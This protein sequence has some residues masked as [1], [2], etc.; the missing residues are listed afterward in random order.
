M[1]GEFTFTI[2]AD[3]LSR[4]LR[5]SK[6]MP[7]DSKYLVE[8][9]GALGRD[10]VLVAIDELTRL[11]TSV[12][13]ELFPYPQ[14][15][16]FTNFILVC[17]ET[18]IYEYSGGV[19][20]LVFTASAKGSTWTAVD[21]YN[22]LYMSNGKVAVVKDPDTG[23]YSET[24]LLPTAVS[25]LNFNGQVILGS[26]NTSP[27]KVFPSNKQDPFVVTLEMGGM[28]GEPNKR[29]QTAI[30]PKRVITYSRMENR[31]LYRQI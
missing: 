14:I 30:W 20:T 27:W 28:W 18:K 1:P 17:G 19:L 6:R 4:G 10:G 31:N 29:I 23:V 11:D 16:V 12:I 9:K 5:P 26:P 25:I 8:S 21:F 22:Y 15:F 13:N 2:T 24:L 3:Q 7:R